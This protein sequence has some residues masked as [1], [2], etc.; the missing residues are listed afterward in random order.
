MSQLSAAQLATVQEYLDAQG[1]TFKP[2]R[3][4]LFDHLLEDVHLQISQGMSFE[5]A[6]AKI[7]GEIPNHHFKTIQTETMEAIQKRLSHSKIFTYLSLFLLALSSLF[8][9]LHLP[10]AAVLL[11]A[12]MVSV[13]VS[14]LVNSISGIRMYKDKRGGAILLLTVFGVL[15]FFASWMLQILHFPGGIPLR[16]TGVGLLLILFPALT[17]YFN[18]HMK[19]ENSILVYVHQKHTTGIIK[20]LVI[21][22]C[23][24]IVLQFLSIIFSW[25]PGI[26]K[27]LLIMVAI[28]GGFQYFALNW[29]PGTLSNSGKRWV[30]PALIIS[31]ICFIITTLGEIVPIEWRIGMIVGYYII[32]GLLAVNGLAAEESKPIAWVLYMVVSVLFVCWGLIYTGVVS[33]EIGQFIFNVPV[34]LALIAGAFFFRKSAILGTYMIIVL[35]HY[36]YEYPVVVGG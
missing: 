20:F 12:S 17:V 6:W 35:A 29:H 31:F 9:V 2:L 26:A 30:I 1:L 22:L 34:L 11:V 7:T 4:E 10:G 25:S 21:L 5:M 16:Y 24:G 3:E 14:F 19:S 18:N 28:I 23:F 36:L 15:I 8:K 13:A 27:L 32:A 33:S